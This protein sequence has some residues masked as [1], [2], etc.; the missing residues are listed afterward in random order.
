MKEK[1]R[2]KRRNSW[3]KAVKAVMLSAT[4]QELINRHGSLAVSFNYRWEHVTTV[5][6]LAKR[7]A[8]LTG[9]D[10]DVVEA[11]A[12]LHDVRKESRE[13]HALAGAQFARSFL[14]QTTFPRKKIERVAHAI[15]MHMG[16]W[17]NEPLAELEAMILWDADKLSK[18]GLTA[19]FHWTGGSLAGTTLTNVHAIIERSNQS[20]WQHKTVASMHTKPAKR[21]AKSRLKAYNKLWQAL[22]YE[23]NGDDLR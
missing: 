12:W 11:A 16:L 4:E 1:K 3:V 14:P 8:V 15:E 21:A 6:R 9:A 7:L 2:I 13:N 17:R 5:V 18:I 19:V 10:E 23:L 22:E 20:D